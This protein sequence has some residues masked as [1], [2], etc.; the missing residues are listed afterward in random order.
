MFWIRVGVKRFDFR[1]VCCRYTSSSSIIPL[2]KVLIANRGE[3]SCRIIRSSKKLGLQTVAVYSEADKNAL[4]VTLADEAYCLGPA[5]SQESYLNQSKVISVAK[6]TG[7]QAIHPGYGFLSEN[8]E[9]AELCQKQGVEFIGPPPSAIRDMGIKSTSKY[10][11]DKAGVPI[12][13]GYH[14]EDQSD[15]RLKNEAVKIGFPVMLKA[16]RGGGGKGMRIA[17]SLE[18]F[19]AQLESA[20]REAQKSFGNDAMLVEKYVKRPRHVEVQ[21]FGDKYGNYV[22][23]FERDCSVQRRHQ[24]IIEEAPAPGLDEA[25]RRSLGEAA[26]RAAEAVNY[27]GAGTVEFIMDED[28]KFYFMEMNTRL[29]V[30]HP[31][32]EMITGTDL[33]EWQLRIA[34]GEKLHVTQEDLKIRGHAFEAR[35]YAEDPE[36]NF[37]PG[38]GHLFRLFTPQASEDVRIETGVREGDDVSVHYD[39]MIAKLVVWGPDRRCA[40]MKLHSALSE[41]NIVGVKTNVKFLMQLAEH[42]EFALGNVHT[43]FIPQHEKEILTFKEPSHQDVCTAVLSA[44]TLDASQRNRDKNSPFTQLDGMVP[45]LTYTKKIKLVFKDKDYSLDVH[46][47]GNSIYSFFIEDKV[48]SMQVAPSKEDPSVLHCT[49]SNKSFPVRAVIHDNEIH[50]FSKDSSYQFLLPTPKFQSASAAETLHKGAIAPMPG[51]IEKINVKVGDKVK[52]GDPLVVL[53]AMKMEY[54]IKSHC[55]GTVQKVNFDVGANVT[56]NAQLV[57]VNEEVS[58]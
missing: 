22:Y 36:E 58:K 48:Y 21:V 10:I 38:A 15:E 27:V 16:V 39:P 6:E 43:D 28:R 13:K 7:A 8:A 56:K 57:E 18:E 25:T 30:E 49:K 17:S 44:I 12:I 5:A 42:E 35:I 31:V 26:V 37:M 11:M 33:V 50:L 23:L 4:H 55:N 32:T 34:A 52:K 19:D 53:I 47:E 20:R 46:Y 51:V 3:I 54:V 40:L 24:K 2:K 41:Y 1:K 14:G 45:N 9:F 29:Q